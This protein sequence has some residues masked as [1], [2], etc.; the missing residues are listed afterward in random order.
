EPLPL[1][2]RRHRVEHGPTHL[3]HQRAE[4]LLHVLALEI[5]VIGPFPVEAQDRNAPLVDG[6]GIELAVAVLVRDHLAPSREPDVRAVVLPVVRLELLPVSTSAG[7]RL[8]STE[9]PV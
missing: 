4:R 9:E 1:L 7:I 6:A 2:L 8:D 3:I 5:L